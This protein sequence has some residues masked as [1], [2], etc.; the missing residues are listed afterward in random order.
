MN[1]RQYMEKGYNLGMRNMLSKEDG[2]AVCKETKA[3]RHL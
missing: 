1:T 2:I 3:R